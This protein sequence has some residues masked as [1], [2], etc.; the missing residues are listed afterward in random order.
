MKKIYYYIYAYN[1]LHILTILP[2]HYASCAHVM[3]QEGLGAN[4]N[5]GSLNSIVA[6]NPPA[7]TS[8]PNNDKHQPPA[9]IH[10]LF[11]I[12]PADLKQNPGMINIVILT[13]NALT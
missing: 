5:D 4:A 10:T 7:I 12:I 9:L 6:N 13:P 11:S 8:T 3:Y 1:N 2:P